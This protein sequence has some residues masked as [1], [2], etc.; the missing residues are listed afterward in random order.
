F[1]TYASLCI[2]RRMLSAV[3][4]S[5]AG[6]RIPSSELVSIDEEEASED[7]SA[8]PTD[9]AVL[10]QQREDTDRFHSRLQKNLTRREYQVLMLYL[11][12][13][14]YEEIAQLLHTSVKS[15]DNALQRVR[16]KLTADSLGTTVE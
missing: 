7:E 16:R 14:S 11:G 1:R 10:L 12:A 6:H 15:V 13:Y 9:P 4:R 2:R 8:V 5:A 3:R